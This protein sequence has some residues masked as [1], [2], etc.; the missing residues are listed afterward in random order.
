MIAPGF[1]A[2]LGSGRTA[3]LQVVADGSDAASANIALGYASA[4]AQGFGAERPGDAAARGAGGAP[5]RRTRPGRPRAARLLQPRPQEPLV[6]RARRPGHG[7]HGHDDAALGHGR[8]CARRRSGRWSSS[9]SPRSGRGSSWSASSLPF[10]LIGLF[11]VLPRH[12]GDRLRLRRAAA[13]LV[14]RC[15]SASAA[16]FLLSTLGLGLLVSTLVQNQQQAM[17]GAAFAA[18]DADDL[19]LGPDLPDREHAARPSSSSP[20]PSPC[21]TTPRSSAASSCAARGSASSGPRRWCCSAWA[22]AS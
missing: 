16:L 18:D 10:A 22:S 1:G 11:Q 8:S 7:P 13:G 6:L 3:A 19:P 12:R 21:A 20:T 2:A 15:S 17:M 5:R 9:S 14:S 4:V